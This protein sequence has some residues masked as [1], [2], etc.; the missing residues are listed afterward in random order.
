M[1]LRLARDCTKITSDVKQSFRGEERSKRQGHFKREPRRLWA[2]QAGWAATRGCMRMQ[3]GGIANWNGKSRK[4]SRKRR[5]SCWR[6]RGMWDPQTQQS[7]H[8]SSQGSHRC[9]GIMSYASDVLRTSVP[10][11]KRWNLKRRSNV[12][13]SKQTRSRAFMSEMLL[14]SAALLTW[15][16]QAERKAGEIPCTRCWA[17]PSKSARCEAKKPL[18]CSLRTRSH[19]SYLQ[20][21]LRKCLSMNCTGPNL[22]PFGEGGL[23][24]ARWQ[25]NT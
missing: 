11:R 16:V 23:K 15:C 21:L 7:Q 22:C 9:T 18:G 2:L 5:S 24:R 3:R 17:R 4:R 20:V 25:W 1:Q 6:C 10:C 13:L 8:G 12:N 14:G 19:A